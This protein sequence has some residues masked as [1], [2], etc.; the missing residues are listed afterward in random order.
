MYFLL[1]AGEAY[2]ETTIHLLIMDD[3]VKLVSLASWIFFI[4]LFFRFAVEIAHL[5]LISE[6]FDSFLDLLL[7]EF[8]RSG[9]RWSF[10]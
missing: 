8:F 9:T 3:V 4:G 5:N 6:R 10:R 7:S 2:R 1:S